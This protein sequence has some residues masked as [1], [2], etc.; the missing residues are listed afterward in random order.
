MTDLPETFLQ[1]GSGKFLR[2]F[3]D[4]FIHQ[5][6]AEGERAGRVVVVQTTGDQRANLLTD[7]GGRYHVLI[8]GL[9]EGTVVERVEPVASISRALVASARW[10]EVLSVARAP[11]LRWVL[12]NTAEAGYTLSPDDRPD[13]APPPSFPA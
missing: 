6:N 2:A 1:F 12:S 8:R 9:E 7:Q 11:E 5:A 10:Q 4:L 13:A 3:A